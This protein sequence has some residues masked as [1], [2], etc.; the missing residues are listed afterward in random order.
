M[1]HSRFLDVG[2][3]RRLHYFEAFGSGVVGECL[4]VILDIEF[5]IF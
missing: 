1:F 3:L 4:Y 5:I 2:I